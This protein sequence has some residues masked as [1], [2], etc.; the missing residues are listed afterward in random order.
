MWASRSALWV[1]TLVGKGPKVALV[2]LV[3]VTDALGKLTNRYS[4]FAVQPL[5]SVHSTPP[6]TV[7][8]SFVELKEAD[9]FAVAKVSVKVKV[10]FRSVTAPPPV[11]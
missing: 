7:Q 5:H 8:P 4:A 2:R 11:T 6:P 1:N 3:L 9:S 10:P